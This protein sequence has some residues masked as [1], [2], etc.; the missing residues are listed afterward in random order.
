MNHEAGT[1]CKK[2]TKKMFDK[3]GMEDKKTKKLFAMIRY[4]T[5]DYQF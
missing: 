2:I 1:F 4:S 3:K 5:I